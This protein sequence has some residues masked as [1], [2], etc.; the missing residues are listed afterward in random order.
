MTSA[1]WSHDNAWLIT[2]SDDRTANVWSLGLP[3]PVMTLETVKHNFGSNKEGGLK[4]DKVSDRQS[5]IVI[6]I[7]IYIAP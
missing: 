5:I 2:S 4:P 6:V 7:F 3:D 1:Y